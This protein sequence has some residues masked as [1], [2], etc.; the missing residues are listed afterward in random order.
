MFSVGRVLFLRIWYTPMLANSLTGRTRYCICASCP[1]P[2]RNGMII[3]FLDSG[4]GRKE[5]DQS[6][7][8]PKICMG[9]QACLLECSV[10]AE[11]THHAV[12]SH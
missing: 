3:S 10:R 11:L 6:V 9:M 8:Q 7:L 5:L 4:E 2:M 1:M 12:W